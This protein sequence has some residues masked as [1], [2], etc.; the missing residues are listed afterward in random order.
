MTILESIREDVA[1]LALEG[2][3]DTTGAPELESHVAGLFAAGRSR[4]VLDFT[5][6]KFVSSIGLRVIIASAKRAAAAGGVLILAAAP[7][8]VNDV[9]E[10]ANIGRI[11]S[12]HAGVDA[13]VAEAARQPAVPDPRQG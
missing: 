2:R 9:F 4:I 13:A 3:L 6:V 5:A 7:P 10:I 1:V 11:L 12:I 8:M